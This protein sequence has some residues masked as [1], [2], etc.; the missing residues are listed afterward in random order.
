MKNKLF[1]LIRCLPTLFVS[2]FVFV[3]FFH[4]ISYSYSI[5]ISLVIYLIDIFNQSKIDDINDEIDYLKKEIVKLQKN[6]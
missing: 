1:N 2:Q 5:P 4:N 6:K 3:V